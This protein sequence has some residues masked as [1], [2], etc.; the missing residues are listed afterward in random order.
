MESEEALT[1][2]DYLENIEVKVPGP[3][4]LSKVISL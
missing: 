3:W 1:V 4:D 2:E